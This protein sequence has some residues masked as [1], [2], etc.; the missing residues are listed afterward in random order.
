[1]TYDLRRIPGQ[2]L[3]HKSRLR[4]F[5]GSKVTRRV[6]AVLFVLTDVILIL[7]VVLPFPFGGKWIMVLSG[8]MTPTM[9]VG[10]M[11][12]MTPVEPASIQMG[13]IISHYPPGYSDV[14]L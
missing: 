9:Q 10:G 14:L 11:V 7:F 5:I 1:M 4:K 8:S 2:G 6:S 3:G 13:D 12:L